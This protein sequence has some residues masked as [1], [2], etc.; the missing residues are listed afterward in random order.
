MKGVTIFP[1]YMSESITGTGNF[2]LSPLRPRAGRFA[3]GWFHAHAWSPRAPAPPSAAINENHMLGSKEACA[4][5]KRQG[6]AGGGQTISICW[7][8]VI[9]PRLIVHLLRELSFH[10]F[11]HKW[12]NCAIWL[13][14]ENVC[15]MT[16]LKTGV[17]GEI[18]SDRYVLSWLPTW[19]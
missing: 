11:H 14:H 13:Q 3:E 16:P 15:R 5:G 18:S 12:N 10:M 17:L 7:K 2:P 1:F 8:W 19:L 9:F 4:L 6:M